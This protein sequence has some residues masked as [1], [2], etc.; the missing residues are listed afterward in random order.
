MIRFVKPNAKILKKIFPEGK[1]NVITR[2]YPLTAEELKKKT[3]LK[4][5]GELYLLGFSGQT[6]KYL[7]EAERVK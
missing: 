6:E 5:G 1:A 3:K 2:N 7:V 4:D